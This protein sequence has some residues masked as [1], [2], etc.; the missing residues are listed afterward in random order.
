MW[1]YTFTDEHHFTWG[2]NAVTPRPNWPVGPGADVSISKTPPSDETDYNAM[3]FPQWKQIGR[4][5]L[6]KSNINNWLSCQPGSGSLVDW[7]DGSISCRIVNHVTDDC[8]LSPGTVPSTLA[9]LEFG[10]VLNTNLQLHGHY[11][12]FDGS[13]VSNW[14]THDPCGVNADNYLKDVIN[15]HGNI[16]VR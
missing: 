7:Q 9:M 6:I 10:P 8:K 5:F 15:P 3:N 14:P 12:Y 16:F 4:E 1:S 11:Y 2:S 13:T